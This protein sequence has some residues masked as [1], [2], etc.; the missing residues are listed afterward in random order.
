MR[1][2]KRGRDIGRGRSRLPEEPDAGLDPRVLGS[3]PK[4][5]AEAQP[6]SHPGFPYLFISER[7]RVR[8]HTRREGAGGRQVS[9]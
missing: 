5:R 2:M 6:L 9:H 3:Q 1:H 7:E 8:K 4:P